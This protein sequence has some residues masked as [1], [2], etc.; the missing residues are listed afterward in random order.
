MPKP[1]RS[2]PQTRLGIELLEDRLTPA[3][4]LASADAYTITRDQT[5]TAAVTQGVLANDTSAGAPMRAGVFQGPAHGSLSLAVD[6]S[7][8]Y[9]PDPGFTGTDEFYYHV[10]DTAGGGR[11]LYTVDAATDQLVALDR[12][13]GNFRIVGDIGY[14]MY[15]TDIAALNGVIYAVT[16]NHSASN[17]SGFALVGIDVR[18]GAKVSV[19]Q[20]S[21]SNPDTLA[22]VDGL[23]VVKGELLIAYIANDLSTSNIGKINLQTGHITLVQG[24]GGGQDFDGIGANENGILYAVNTEAYS[25]P[26]KQIIFQQFTF[27]PSP[28]VFNIRDDVLSNAIISDLAFTPFGM[29]AIDNG[30]R[31]IHRY[32]STTFVR[33]D[34]FAMGFG[35]ASF[36][37][38]DWAAD[39]AS[40]GKVT[41]TVGSGPGAPAVT[42][43]TT[44]EDTQT[45]SIVVTRGATNGPEVTHFKIT[46]VRNGTLY[47]H[48][49]ATV[50]NNGDFITVA[51]G[52][53][54]LKFTPAPN[55]N[56]GASMFS[57]DVQASTSASGAG[58]GDSVATA[59]VTVTPVNDAPA[60][61]RGADQTVPVNS[62]PQVVT[63]W[64][65]GFSAGPGNE[66]GQSVLAYEVIGNTN[67]AL[68]AVAPTI[69]P[70]GTLSYTPA[71]GALGSAEITIVVRDDGGISGG[72]AN[73]STPQ[74]FTIAVTQVVVV[75]PP[76]NPLPS[77]PVSPVA[78]RTV[79]AV[80][81]PVGT[82]S[83]ARLIDS[84]TGAELLRVIPF[85]G[86]S[87]GISV[88]A[89][90]LNGD[91]KADL[92][93]GAGA[94]GNT[95][96]RAF[97][98]ATGA[99]LASFLAYRGFSGGISVAVGDVNGDG[100]GDIVTGVGA[101]APGGHVKA[102]NVVA[103]TFGGLSVVS[104]DAIASFFAYDGAFRGGVSVATGDVNGD[105]IADI[106]TGSGPGA[107][108]GHVKAFSGSTRTELASF[109]A[110]SGFTGGLRVSAADLDG[111][112]AAEV[113]VLASGTPHV[114]VFGKDGSTRS[115]Y[116]A[117][118]RPGYS[119]FGVT[120]ADVNRDGIAEVVTSALTGAAPQLRAFRGAGAAQIEVPFV[121]PDD[122]LG[123]I[124]VG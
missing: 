3:N 6:G 54:G 7:F 101:G 56:S 10:T 112:G 37:G 4:P 85:A 11:T 2:R 79:I 22:D 31:L 122:I 63:G 123:G 58:V 51:E 95:H 12:D 113:V 80:G 27:Q 48:D 49:G 96:V 41:I 124:E 109:Y 62:G 69:A 30:E 91:G 44:N 13:T 40:V 16:A 38:I 72:G 98:G 18:T 89:G 102:F 34:T 119:A 110:F 67:P 74:R 94:G 83:Q 28:N 59:T 1:T 53:A 114:K 60:F 105:G 97:D 106:I 73:Q 50:I 15:A 47:K 45:G 33:E 77:T 103:H 107:P 115:S 82:P 14:D 88:A 20:L 8:V 5:L 26:L 86:F 32:N 93:V 25:A 24:F 108:N 64:A 57:F 29:Y 116:L 84:R 120:T 46:N 92:V 90:D 55:L 65:A 66:S 61:T 21:T 43:V 39:G 71:T 104:G 35:A 70:D 117:Y 118:P 76:G 100:F 99:E 121:L 81:S 78:A 75:D 23:A 19:V 87:G 52:T 68:F 36:I 9:T 111:D 42:D 17:P